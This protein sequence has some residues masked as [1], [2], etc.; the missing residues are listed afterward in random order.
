MIASE[1][2][3]WLCH[4]TH[5]LCPYLVTG[6]MCA[7]NRVSTAV[8]WHHLSEI[9]FYVGEVERGGA[10]LSKS[11]NTKITKVLQLAEQYKQRGEWK[12]HTWGWDQVV[13]AGVNT[14]VNIHLRGLM[15]QICDLFQVHWGKT[16]NTLKSG[17]CKRC[18]E[19][20]FNCYP[21]NLVNLLLEDAYAFVMYMFCRISRQNTSSHFLMVYCLFWAST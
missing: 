16:W 19:F 18:S 7:S 15:S 9:V 2:S 12:R 10:G 6:A 1:H 17:T 13:I 21:D 3:S 11:P 4:P 5:I 8:S 20:Y 14:E